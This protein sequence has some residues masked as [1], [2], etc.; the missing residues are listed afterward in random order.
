[1]RKFIHNL[2][3]KGI[4]ASLLLACISSP[5]QEPL[6]G[7]RYAKE[8][9][10]QGNEWENPELIA[11]NKEQPVA[12]FF[13]FHDIKSARTILPENSKWWKSLDGEWSFHWS[14]NPSERPA[15]FHQS[16]FD[17][18]QWDKITVPSNWNLV[19]LKKDGSQK[20]GTPIYVNQPVIFY[21]E[22]K[23]DDWKEGVMRTPPANWTTY[24]HRNEVGSYMKEFSLPRK[25]QN[26]EI[27]LHFDGVDSFFYLWVNGQYVGFSKN[28]RNTA[29]FDITSY[30]K[31]GKNTVAVEVYRSSDGSFLEAQDMFRLPGIYRSVYLTARSKTSVKDLVVIPEL[32]SGNQKGVLHIK[33]TL[34]NYLPEDKNNYTLT[35]S[36][37]ANKLYSDK[38]SNSPVAK[39]YSMPCFIP[40]Q[41]ETLCETKL[42]L[43]HP[44]LWSAE[45]PNCYTLVAELKNKQGNVKEIVSTLVGFREIEI[46]DTPAEQD[47]FGLAGRY[48]YFNGKTIKF[49]GVNRHEHN[50]VT[51]HH[52]SRE[53]MMQDVILMKKANINHVRNCHYPDDPYWYYL[54]NRYGIYLED[55]ANIESHEY[56]Y[57][58]A[59]LSHPKEWE[60]A[61]VARVMEMVHAHVNHPSI[62]I[63]SLGN[64]AGPGHNFVEAYNHLKEFDASRPVQY[65]RNNDIVDMGSNQYPSIRWTNAAAT[66]KLNIKYPFHIS[67]YAHSMGN[68]VGNLADYWK[69]IES[70]NYICGGA[71]WDW[72][73]QALYNYTPD[74]RRYLAYGGDFG[75]FPNDG[76]FV[77]NGII[78]AD[79][80]L[81]PQYHEVKKVYQNV[82]IS[83][84]DLAKKEFQIFNKSYFTDM[85]NYQLNWQLV[86]N[87]KTISSGGTSLAPIGPREKKTVRINYPDVPKQGE[88]FI[89]F[90][91]ALKKSLPWADKGYA[92]YDEQILLQKAQNLPLIQDKSFPRP[93]VEEN[94]DQILVKGE[95]WSVRFSNRTGNIESLVYDGKELFSEGKGPRLHA[96]RAFTNN[97]NWMYESWFQNGLHNLQQ[98]AEGKASVQEN[99][100]HSVTINY[101]VEVQA[102]NGATIHGGTSSGHN[103]IEEHISRPFSKEDFRIVANQ[104]WTVYGDGS[105]ELRTSLVSNRPNTVLPRLG[106]IMEL[107]DKYQKIRYYGRGPIA[108]YNDRRTSQNIGLYESTVDQEY[109]HFPKPQEMANHEECRWIQ[110]FDNNGS[111]ASF[112]AHTQFSTSVYR[113]SDLELTLASHVHELPQT[114]KIYLHL[115]QMVTGLGGN[116]CG[117]GGPMEQDKTYGTETTF[118]FIL[119]PI[120]KNIQQVWVKSAQKD[121][122]MPSL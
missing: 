6:K 24:K 28:S 27:F 65:E 29:S 60:N 7:F 67:E 61:H 118:G 64:E 35:Y 120:S 81:K 18:S 32:N 115:D 116:S 12:W 50:P 91:F 52:L 36:L 44:N 70:S 48:Y 119:R 53:D 55:E 71:I 89:N 77:M 19:G 95:K 80:T 69:A 83:V 33:S 68:A 39:A 43:E 37:Y 100:D 4:A 22:V 20:Y 110:L 73:D 92:Q 72:V 3:Q 40:S 78:F 46:R 109:V 45:E 26:K 13:N 49:K 21:H 2:T 9:A 122:Q 75:D 90:Q 88:T 63:W 87:G 14:A 11:L 121:P 16:N 111:G 51:G 23:V 38:T 85:S 98:K 104:A 66:G 30:L 62:A 102:P 99:L 74:G 76:Q 54:C 10:P 86:N 79:R 84:H 106:Y 96:F 93:F 47:E 117:Q 107:P 31:E 97:D 17:Y 112:I 56:Y 8:T 25:W 41:Q 82:A 114:G 34:K 58:D 42:T 113:N 105:V 15:D 59:S 57:G 103:T 108:N 5:A 1:M 94:E 101:R